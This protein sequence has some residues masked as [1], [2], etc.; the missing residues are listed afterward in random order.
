MV[1]L[2][3]IKMEFQNYRAAL[4]II[5]PAC[6]YLNNKKHVN[7]LHKFQVLIITSMTL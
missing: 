5:Y 3:E 1:S 7:F 4:G 6:K 2:E